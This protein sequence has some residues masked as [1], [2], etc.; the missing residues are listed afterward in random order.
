[1]N[2]KISVIIPCYNEQERIEKT[3]RRS[4]VFLNDN[5]FEYEIMLVNDGSTDATLT[6]FKRLKIQYKYID[7]VSYQ[8][9]YGK[10]FAVSQGLLRSKYFTKVIIDADNSVAL[11][12]LYKLNWDWIQ[13]T[14]VIKGQRIQAVR[15]PIYRLFVG[16]CF[17][18]IVWIFTGLYLDSQ[19]PFTILR[20]S[21]DFYLELEIDGFAYDV[22]ILYIA[23]QY[24]IPINKI[25]VEYKNDFDS[26][27]TFWKSLLMLKEIKKIKKK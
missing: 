21:Q 24:N 3:V 26:K 18:I 27:V 19:S 6:V 1:M 20:L 12:E 16:K 14:E 9:N 23:K 13:S 11:T 5:G 10:G 2:K 15:Q 4:I 17:K 7:Y 8:K 25:F 22:E